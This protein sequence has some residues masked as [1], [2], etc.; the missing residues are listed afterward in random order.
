MRVVI[1]ETAKDLKMEITFSNNG[2]GGIG[3][4]HDSFDVKQPSVGREAVDAARIS[5]S[6]TLKVSS[7]PS[8]IQTASLASAEP[9]LD[10]PDEALLRDDPLGKLVSSVFN[11]PPPPMP[12]FSGAQ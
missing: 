11:L 4:S 5:H 10:I 12:Q 6:A 3:A 7:Q 1:A 8:N 9:V 2:F